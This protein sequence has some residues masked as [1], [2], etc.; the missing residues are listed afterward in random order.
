METS[1]D[2]SEAELNDSVNDS[3]SEKSRERSDLDENEHNVIEINR[4]ESLDNIPS[5]DCKKPVDVS[6]MEN[7]NPVEIPDSEE[8]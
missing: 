4:R 3:S 5:D 7:A 8:E 6:D 1:A 2:E